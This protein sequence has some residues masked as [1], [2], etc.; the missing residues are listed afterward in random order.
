M[1]KGKYKLCKYTSGVGNN[2]LSAIPGN[3][4]A[5]ISNTT[6]SQCVAK[7]GL[8]YHTLSCYMHKPLHIAKLTFMTSQK[9][10]LLFLPTTVSI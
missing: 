8:L 6:D 2:K 1:V 3:T 7:L 4:S 9:S 5:F 10:S